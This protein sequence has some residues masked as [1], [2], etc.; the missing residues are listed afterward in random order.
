MH[1]FLAKA[2]VKTSHTGCHMGGQSGTVQIGIGIL[3]ADGLLLVRRGHGG[4]TVLDYTTVGCSIKIY[5]TK[6]KLVV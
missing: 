3:G 1:R 4:E 2:A 5:T 6:F